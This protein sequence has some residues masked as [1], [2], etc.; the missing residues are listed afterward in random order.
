MLVKFLWEGSIE[1]CWS[2]AVKVV[3]CYNNGAPEQRSKFV[4][5]GDVCCREE[6]GCCAFSFEGR[7]ERVLCASILKAE[8]RDQRLTDFITLVFIV[9]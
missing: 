4:K 1:M 3:V 7:E 8:K 5:K 2:K 6:R 9:H